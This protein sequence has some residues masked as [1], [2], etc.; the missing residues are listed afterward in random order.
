MN[1]VGADTRIATSLCGRGLSINRNH[2]I[3]DRHIRHRLGHA[4]PNKRICALRGGGGR[5]N[6]VIAGKAR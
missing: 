3:R 2:D 5:Y 4:H 1:S 6:A